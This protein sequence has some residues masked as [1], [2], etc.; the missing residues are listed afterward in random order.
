MDGMLIATAAPPRGIHFDSFR[1]RELN[2]PDGA[3]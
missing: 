1:V 3:P 2:V